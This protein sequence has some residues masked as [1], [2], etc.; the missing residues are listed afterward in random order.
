MT[1]EYHEEFDG[2]NESSSDK[3]QKLNGVMKQKIGTTIKQFWRSR[4]KIPFVKFNSYIYPDAQSGNLSANEDK[5][6]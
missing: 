5:I 2:Q 4:P 1:Y 3:H 6:A